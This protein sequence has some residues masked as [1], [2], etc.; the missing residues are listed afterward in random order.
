MAIERHANHIEEVNALQLRIAQVKAELIGLTQQYDRLTGRPVAQRM[1]VTVDVAPSLFEYTPIRKDEP[2]G[3][4]DP[5]TIQQARRM[6][7]LSRD[8]R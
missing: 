1:T 4:Y 7:R 3:E 8:I 5:I 2:L 6:R